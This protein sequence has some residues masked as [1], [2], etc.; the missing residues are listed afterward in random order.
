MKKETIII[1]I[2]DQCNIDIEVQNVKG[3]SCE[4]MVSDL[5]ILKDLNIKE[6]KK[7]KEYYVK[8]DTTITNKTTNKQFN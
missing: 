5:G 6:K 2:D 8:M 3:P 4:K 1:D 7:K